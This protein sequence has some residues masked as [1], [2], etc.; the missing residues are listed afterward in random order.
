VPPELVTKIQE[1]VYELRVGEVMTKEVISV[2]PST[3]MRELRGIL[4]ERR[5]SGTPVVEDGRLVGIISIED[6]INWLADGGS[7]CPVSH[8]MTREVRTIH[9]DEPLLQ[10]VNSLE[11]SGFGR[12]PV[13]TRDAGRLVGVV[14]KGDIV[15][16]LLHHLEVDY[17]DA[18]M[19]GARSSHIFEDIVA[20]RTRLML[21]YEVR[22][23]DFDQAGTS[24][25]RLKTS[26]RRVGIDPP[27]A[28]RVAIAAYEAEMNLIVFTPGGRISVELDPRVLRLTAEDEGPGIPDVERAMAPGFSTAP[29]WVRELGFGAGMGLPNINRCADRMRLDSTVGRGTRLEVEIFMERQDDRERDRAQAGA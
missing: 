8:R 5:I 23:G 7:D 29:D 18:E 26:L 2:A 10:A 4:R 9:D 24:A 1:M 15:S 25:S 16:G 6:F 27:T 19:R 20:D 12:L 28:R 21:E 11:R 17:R 3:A 14:T 13:C 22:G